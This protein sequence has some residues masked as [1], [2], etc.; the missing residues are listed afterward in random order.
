M[1]I[2]Y[3]RALFSSF[4]RKL[5]PNKVLLILGARRVGKTKLIQ[6]FLKTQENRL[7]KS[8]S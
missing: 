2:H 4:Q 1:E 8:L 7:C 3:Q 6:D 5:M